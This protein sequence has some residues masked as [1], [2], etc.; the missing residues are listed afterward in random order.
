[1]ADD[2][3]PG[4]IW[5][6]AHDIGVE[7]ALWENYL[8]QIKLEKAQNK[9]MVT[10]QMLMSVQPQGGGGS[11]KTPLPNKFNGKK[12]DPAFTFLAAC[13]N[14]H[15][16]KLAAFS[17]NIVFIRWALQQME[18]KVGPWKVRQMM[19]MDEEMDDQGNPPQELLDWKEFAEYFLTQFGDPGLIEQAKIME[20]RIEPK[21]QGSRLLRRN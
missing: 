10:Q 20:G 12:G 5:K 4:T 18:D 11:F 1:V 13:N 16:M 8:A 3:Q 19:R 15:I 17:N 6:A 9:A 7:F 14:Y 2:S 21:G